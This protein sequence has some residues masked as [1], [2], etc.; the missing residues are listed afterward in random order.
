M[1]TTHILLIFTTKM[2]P[3]NIVK[4][5]K[6]E[7]GESSAAASKRRKIKFSGPIATTNFPMSSHLLNQPPPTQTTGVRLHQ[8]EEQSTDDGLVSS[9]ITRQNLIMGY[10]MAQMLERVEDLWRQNLTSEVD[11]LKKL[12][13]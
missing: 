12:E 4:K 2:P 6:Q 5:T 13:A 9:L 7:G 10:H 8:D 11:K 3:S 1:G